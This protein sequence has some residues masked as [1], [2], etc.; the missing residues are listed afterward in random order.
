MLV[1]LGRR[2]PRAPFTVIREKSG[3]HHAEGGKGRVPGRNR[4]KI[5]R[6]EK[7]SRGDAGD[8]KIN[9]K[10]EFLRAQEK[11]KKKERGGKYPVNNE[12]L[13]ILF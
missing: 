3:C 12:V 10:G 6:G 1:S 2:E 8:R 13:K 9:P 11:R 7:K 5:V 4:G